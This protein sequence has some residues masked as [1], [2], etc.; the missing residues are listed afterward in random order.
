[1]SDQANRNK[2]NDAIGKALDLAISSLEKKE[3][4]GIEM[5]EALKVFASLASLN[6]QID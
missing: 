5:L 2:L 1:M 6:H 3:A 4:P